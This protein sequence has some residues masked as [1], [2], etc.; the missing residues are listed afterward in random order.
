MGVLDGPKTRA[1][2]TAMAGQFFAFL[3]YQGSTESQMPHSLLERTT[4]FE[5]V[6]ARSSFSN[7]GEW[8]LAAQK[9]MCVLACLGDLVY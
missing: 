4:L 7:A 5:S 1:L 8:D 3:L 2:K 9:I 6:T